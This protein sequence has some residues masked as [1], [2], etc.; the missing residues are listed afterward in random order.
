[1][2]R[3]CA[4]VIASI[5]VSFPLM[6]QSAKAGFEEADERIEGI[7]YAMERMNIKFFGIYQES[8]YFGSDFDIARSLCEF[9]ATL[10]EIFQKRHKRF[11]WPFMLQ[12]NREK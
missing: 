3:S 10:R 8:N 6:Y 4:A 1:M 5:I 2:R 12:W 7:A 9:G 11:R